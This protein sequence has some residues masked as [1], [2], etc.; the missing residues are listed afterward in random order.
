V[1]RLWD[2]DSR[3]KVSVYAKAGPWTVAIAAPLSR[4]RNRFSA[5]SWSFEKLNRQA[6][7][8]AELEQQRQAGLARRAQEGQLDAAERVERERFEAIVAKLAPFNAAFF[9]QRFDALKN[10]LNNQN[11][12]LDAEVIQHT[13]F[14]D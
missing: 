1:T 8:Q 7:Q 10:V 2:T 3:G 14:R 6:R 11:A 4:P 12:D 9:Q 5:P 13:L